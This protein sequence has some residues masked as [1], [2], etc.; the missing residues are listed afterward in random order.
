MTTKNVGDFSIVNVD[1]TV[2]LF[3]TPLIG[4]NHPL[5]ELLTY[6]SWGFTDVNGITVTVDMSIHPIEFEK[7]DGDINL[8]GEHIACFIVQGV[9]GEVEFETFDD[10]FD[11]LYDIL[12]N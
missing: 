10:M 9:D 6:G 5:S 11:E 2:Y 1:G 3:N 4:E 8:L 7:V 12:E